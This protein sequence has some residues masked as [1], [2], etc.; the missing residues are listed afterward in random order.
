M[1]TPIRIGLLRLV[2]SAPV[3]VAEQRGLFSELGLDVT[4]SVEPSWS[5]TADKLAYGLLDAAP[6]RLNAKDTPVPY[7]PNL[8]AAHRPTARSIATA[9]RKLLRQ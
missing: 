4:L 7:H 6:Q 2:D 9:A 8:W 1:T 5:N 3:M